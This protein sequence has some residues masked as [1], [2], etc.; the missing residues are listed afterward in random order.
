MPL[1]I[2]HFK[3]DTFLK[4][5][6]CIKKVRGKKKYTKTKKRSWYIFVF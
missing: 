2:I 3:H 5:Y 4:A 6:P 1:F